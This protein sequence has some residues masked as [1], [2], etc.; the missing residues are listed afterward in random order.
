M[1]TAAGLDLGSRISLAADLQSTAGNGATSA[2]LAEIRSDHKLAAEKGLQEL[3]ALGVGARRG[4]T[5]ATHDSAKMPKFVIERPQQ[6]GT[7]Y[8]AK[9]KAPLLAS[10][11]QEV[12]WPAKGK[13]LIRPLGKGSQYLD[14]TQDWSDRILQGENEHVADN[15]RAYEMTWAKVA[16][17]LGQMADGKPYTGDS[18][19]AVLRAAWADFQKRLPPQLRPDGEKPT[20]ESQED[21]WGIDAP[22]SAYATLMKATRR[23]RDDSSRHTP[24]QVLKESRGN[25]QIDELMDGQSKIPGPPT[26]EVMKE[27]WDKLPT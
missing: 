27:A 5:R 19:E 23:A 18:E 2:F 17:V 8:S 14:V 21:R 9:A 20:R 13:H 16:S 26:D 4:L 1:E 25:D 12:W 7:M 15:D 22:T 24:L 6:S 3:M 11:D 10:L